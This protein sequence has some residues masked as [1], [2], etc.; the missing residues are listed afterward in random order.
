MGH[1][2][3]QASEVQSIYYKNLKINKASGP[4]DLPVYIPI[5]VTKSEIHIDTYYNKN[6]K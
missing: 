2:I 1:R 4:D 6:A 3:W 5:F